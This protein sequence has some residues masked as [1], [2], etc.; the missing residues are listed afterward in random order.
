MQFSWFYYFLR[1]FHAISFVSC[2]NFFFFMALTNHWM[3]IAVWSRVSHKT[4]IKRFLKAHLKAKQQLLFSL[5]AIYFRLSENFPWNLPKIIINFNFSSQPVHILSLHLHNS[6]VHNSPKKFTL[7][8]TFR[9][10]TISISPK[11]PIFLRSH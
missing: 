7:K 6:R 10:Q 11:F 8:S 4:S 1:I 3:L 9:S 5:K 2:K